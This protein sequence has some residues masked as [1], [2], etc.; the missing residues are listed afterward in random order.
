MPRILIISE[1][2]PTALMPEGA[3]LTNALSGAGFEVDVITNGNRG[4]SIRGDRTIADLICIPL[5]MPRSSG[6]LFALRNALFFDAPASPGNY[7][8]LRD[9]LH[10]H[11]QEV[12]YDAVV[13]ICPPQVYL[14]L[15]FWID[16]TFGIPVW[17]H[18][19]QSLND[20]PT[21]GF[22][23]WNHRR[24]RRKYLA[25]AKVITAGA[26]TSL[27]SVSGQHEQLMF[28]AEVQ[29]EMRFREPGGGVAI[30]ASALLARIVRRK[31]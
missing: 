11:L 22:T 14:R 27:R 31:S 21:P 7:S 17:I 30:D 13:I 8:Q 4:S 24:L 12:L 23:A 6:T 2:W 25:S 10:M 1:A 20:A 19:T 9:R 15:G 26:G 16:E 28:I 29:D 3:A 5:E 18:L